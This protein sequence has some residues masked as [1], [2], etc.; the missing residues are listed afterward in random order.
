MSDLSSYDEASEKH[1]IVLRER[2]W[3]DEYESATAAAMNYGDGAQAEADRIQAGV[4]G[5]E[6]YETLSLLLYAIRPTGSVVEYAAV[7]R[8]IKGELKT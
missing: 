7:L 6:R 8:V 1:E 3:M 2:G 4:E 5:L